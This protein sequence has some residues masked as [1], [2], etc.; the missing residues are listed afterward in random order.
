MKF[1][2]DYLNLVQNLSDISTVAEDSM[3]KE[4]A[5]NIIFK[6]DSDGSVTLLGIVPQMLIFKRF[7][8]RDKYRLEF[9]DT[10]NQNF[11]AQLNESGVA[12]SLYFQL[13]SKELTSFLNSYKSVRRT[14]VD[15][16]TFE[17]T[18]RGAIRCTVLEREKD[19][20]GYV[21]DDAKQHLSHWVFN[22]IPIRQNQLPDITITAPDGELVSVDNRCIN[23]Y[24]KNLV[25]IMQ[26]G[27]TNLYSSL[28]CGEDYIVAFDGAFTALMANNQEGFKDVF[29][30]MCLSYR[31]VSFMDKVI[32]VNEDILVCKSDRHL[33]FKTSNSE[34]F[35]TYT[36]NLPAYKAYADA[37]KKDHAVVLDRIYIKDILKRLSLV[38]ESIEVTVDP[39]T[40]LVNL[41]NSK[42]SQDVEILSSKA[43]DELGKIRY[44]IA[45]DKLTSCIIGNDAE[46]NYDVRIYFSRQSDGKKIAIIFTDGTG[47]WFSVLRANTY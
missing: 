30:N 25:P 2:C 38:N 17:I 7:V 14:Q 8:E 28:A 39:E 11:Q 21:S 18:D 40:N 3:L 15:E 46:F 19:D 6:F 32:A 5:K 45:P 22:N 24:T 1:T 27:S 43:M 37:F 9:T 35:I 26:S 42:F 44:K 16:V 12:S 13:K 33:Y 29:S 34:A 47:A 4:E 41:K 36:T 23:L 10:E 20:D 31:A